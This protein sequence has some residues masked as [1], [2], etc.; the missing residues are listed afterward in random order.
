MGH[1][2]RGLLRRAAALGIAAPVVSVMLHAT[3]DMAYGAPTQGRVRSLRR[4]V[5]GGATVPA[6]APTAPE[7]ERS[8]VVRLTVGTYGSRTPCSRM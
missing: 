6:D 1:S 7:G 5:Q 4:L 3:S 2:R 8:P